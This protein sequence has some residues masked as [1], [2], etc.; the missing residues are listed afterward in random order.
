VNRDRYIS[1]HKDWCEDRQVAKGSSV[2]AVVPC[3][4][5][6]QFLSVCTLVQFVIYVLSH[7]IMIARRKCENFTTH[8][9]I[10]FDKFSIT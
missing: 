3:S 5:Y 2:L 9:Y 6:F 4:H 1:G 7:K 10:T 8:E